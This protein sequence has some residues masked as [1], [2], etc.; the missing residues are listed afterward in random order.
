VAISLGDANLVNA[1]GW[2]RDESLEPSSSVFSQKLKD[3]FVKAVSIDEV[4]KN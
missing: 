1:R 2:V 4:V 3:L